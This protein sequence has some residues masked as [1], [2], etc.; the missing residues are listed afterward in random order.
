MPG[1]S[2]GAGTVALNWQDRI[3]GD[4][5]G[6]PGLA[7]PSSQSE[8][9]TKKLLTLQSQAPLRPGVEDQANYALG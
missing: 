5:R 1:K 6:C 8:L 7:Q 9:V 4:E 2:T 3:A